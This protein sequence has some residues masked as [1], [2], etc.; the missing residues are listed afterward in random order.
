MY[1]IQNDIVWFGYSD[2][3]EDENGAQQWYIASI[4]ID[5][6]NLNVAYSGTFYFDE[7][8]DQIYEQHNNN[9]KEELYSSAN[10]F[11]LMEKSF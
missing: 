10:G 6:N 1:V 5:G 8:A 11:M 9:H 7:K 4:T 2:A 3:E